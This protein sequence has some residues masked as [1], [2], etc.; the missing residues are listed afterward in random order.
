M[1]FRC[2]LFFSLLTT[3]IHAQVPDADEERSTELQRHVTKG[4]K[5][6][7]Q[8]RLYA[9]PSSTFV[10]Q[11][12]MNAIK[13]D[14]ALQEVR[15]V[16]ARYSILVG[17]AI[18][19]PLY[20]VPISPTDGILFLQ[21]VLHTTIDDTTKIQSRSI[22][23]NVRFYQQMH[24]A[25]DRTTAL[26]VETWATGKTIDG[27]PDDNLAGEF[28]KAVRRVTEKFA[29]DYIASKNPAAP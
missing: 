7:K 16:L 25:R 10:E 1:P 21:V 26:T 15:A 20:R 4:L 28:L 2:L 11:A 12:T 24:L 13:S 22:D 5:G 18:R 6:L 14:Q 23:V 8:I 9:L 29:T 17:S 19:E 3:A 27:Y